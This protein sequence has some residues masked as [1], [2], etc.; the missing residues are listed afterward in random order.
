MVLFTKCSVVFQML[1]FFF[2]FTIRQFKDVFSYVRI[3]DF[4]SLGKGCQQHVLVNCSFC[5]FLILF[6]CPFPLMLRLIRKIATDV[7][8]SMKYALIQ[9]RV[10]FWI[11]QNS[12]SRVSS[13]N[14]MKLLFFK[15]STNEY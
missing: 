4:P 7:Y 12:R 14:Q 10:S 1:F 11:E 5:G 2:L 9:K 3:T 8:G 15:H 6:V 13:S